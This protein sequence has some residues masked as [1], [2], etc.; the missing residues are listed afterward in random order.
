MGGMPDYPPSLPALPHSAPGKLAELQCEVELLVEFLTSFLREHLAIGESTVTMG[1]ATLAG[2]KRSVLRI[3]R[4]VHSQVKVLERAREEVA[5]VRESEAEL[6]QSQEALLT[7]RAQLLTNLVEA[8]AAR[9]AELARALSSERKYEDLLLRL[10]ELQAEQAK[11]ASKAAAADR[12]FTVTV[13]PAKEESAGLAPL[14]HLLLVKAHS[15]SELRL[16]AA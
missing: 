16:S 10:A 12:E 13:T 7:E 4:L 9:D 11:A 8:R 5:R 14:K 3:M 15:T 2:I 6:R 1:V